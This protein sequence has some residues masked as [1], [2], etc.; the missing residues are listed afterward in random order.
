MIFGAGAIDRFVID[1]DRDRLPSPPALQLA[2]IVQ[3]SEPLHLVAPSKNV[4][5]AHPVHAEKHWPKGRRRSSWRARDVD[6]PPARHRGT[7]RS[8]LHHRGFAGGLDRVAGVDRT[9]ER[10]DLVA[11]KTRRCAR[12]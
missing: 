2:A 10:N 3:P 12:T 8:A 9:A 5:A 4:I 7:A 6:V 1:R 11:R